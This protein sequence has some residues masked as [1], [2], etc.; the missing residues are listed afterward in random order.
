MNKKNA[1]EHQVT[2]KESDSDIVKSEKI[3]HQCTLNTLKLIHSNA[4]EK[5]Y[6]LDLQLS[7]P[8]HTPDRNSIR[9]VLQKVESILKLA[10]DIVESNL[11]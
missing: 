8:D 6:E 5:L 3:N 2:I 1:V 4:L 9:I 7:M 10:N 11:R